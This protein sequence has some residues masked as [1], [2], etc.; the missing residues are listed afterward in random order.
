MLG[1]KY[2]LER[3]LGMGGMA[4]VYLGVHRNGNRVAVKVLH[5]EASA[6]P[7]TVARFRREGYVANSIGHPGAVR[8]LDDDVDDDGSAYLVM[9]LLEGETLHARAR[10]LGG[11][12][13]PREVLALARD[14]CDV[15]AAAH[16]R[17]VIHRD[18]KPD[19][20]FL[21][22]E[23]ALKVL[24]FGIARGGEGADGLATLAGTAMGTPAFMPPEQALGHSREVDAR[25]DVWSAGAT[26]FALLSGFV[27]HQAATAAEIMVAAATRRSRARSTRRHGLSAPI[28][29]LVDRALRFSRDER[30]PSAIALRDAIDEAHLAAFGQRVARS[31]AGPVTSTIA[32]SSSRPYAE[33]FFA[34]TRQATA[35]T[36]SPVST[37]GR[38][39]GDPQPPGPVCHDGGDP[40]TPGPA[41]GSGV[42][43]AA[44]SVRDAGLSSRERAHLAART[45]PLEPL[46]GHRGRGATAGPTPAAA[47]LLPRYLP[48]CGSS[49]PRREAAG[50]RRRARPRRRRGPGRRPRTPRR[51]GW[52]AARAA[53]WSAGCADSRA[54][55]A[56]ARGRP[57]ICRRSDRVCVPIASADC[58]VLAQPGDVGNDA[59]VWIG[60]MFPSAAPTRP[61]SARPRGTRSSSRDATS[62]R[63][64]AGSPR[65]A[66]AAR[67]AL[68]RW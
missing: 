50:P 28:V 5:L 63:R 51:R 6:D 22:M 57:S 47:P 34:V 67:A 39:G 68:W 24:D 9:E 41:G 46:R 15:L 43:P 52:P 32:P 25:S 12:L 4:A 33:L 10:R 53:A 11:Y 16:E 58:K 17:G 55:V 61:S 38:D 2:A 7:G 8:V 62:P 45:D 35:P 23:R 65:R 37:T 3:V 19:N 64:W 56:A 66:P 1:G 49:P 13:P 29:A 54:C 20:L 44:R 60:A 26:M 36:L 14:L 48:E 59:T 40:Q 30:W 42:S 21:T 18:I 27:V 31:A